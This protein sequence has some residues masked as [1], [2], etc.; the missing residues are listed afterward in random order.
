MHWAFVCVI[1]DLLAPLRMCMAMS[2]GLRNTAHFG[3]AV[4][5]NFCRVG[6]KKIKIRNSLRARSNSKLVKNAK[7]Y[8][9]F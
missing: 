3:I 1:I 2:Y 5:C 4:Y 7:N 6:K 9:Q 8:P